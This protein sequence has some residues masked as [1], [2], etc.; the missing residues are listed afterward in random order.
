MKIVL[1]LKKQTCGKYLNVPHGEPL[2]KAGNQ[3]RK[4]FVP[5]KQVAKDYVDSLR[6]RLTM[7]HILKKGKPTDKDGCICR[8]ILNQRRTETCNIMM[9]G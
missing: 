8:Q 1:I 4:C 9:S 3:I 2:E 7:I 5:C 6:Y